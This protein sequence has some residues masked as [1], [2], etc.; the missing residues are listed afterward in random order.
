MFLK[1][2]AQTLL[3]MKSL[4][5]Q[6]LHAAL[7]KVTE[8]I[9]TMKINKNNEIEFSFNQ[10]IYSCR[11]KTNNDNVLKTN[12]NHLTQCSSVIRYAMY[13]KLPFLVVPSTN[14]NKE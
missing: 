3:T 2:K 1:Y 5:C 8:T 14:N 7:G 11:G 4:Y 6:L 13:S 10:S 12:Y 9:K